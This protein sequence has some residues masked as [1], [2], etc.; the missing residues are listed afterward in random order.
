MRSPA[1]FNFNGDRASGRSAHALTTAE[2]N[3][4][5]RIFDDQVGFG[6]PAVLKCGPGLRVRFMSERTQR[7]FHNFFATVAAQVSAES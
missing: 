3:R 6:K 5:F 7:L 2:N 4:H 1:A